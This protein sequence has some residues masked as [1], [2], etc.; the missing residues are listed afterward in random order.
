M[1]HE[2]NEK[3]YVFVGYDMETMIFQSAVTLLTCSFRLLC[4][5]N[6]LGVAKKRIESTI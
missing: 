3:K 5:R 1:F 6:D 4:E 2:Q